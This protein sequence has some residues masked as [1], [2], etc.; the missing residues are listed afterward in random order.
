MKRRSSERDDTLDAFFEGLRDREDAPRPQK[1]LEEINALVHLQLKLNNEHDARVG[2]RPGMVKE[3]IQDMVAAQLTVLNATRLIGAIQNRV[4]E[5]LP[6]KFAAFG[7]GRS[8]RY[9]H[10]DCARRSARAS[11]NA[12]NAQIE[13]DIDAFLQRESADTDAAKLRLL[14]TLSQGTRA[15]FD[16]KT[17]KQVKQVFMPL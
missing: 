13:R 8:R 16:Q 9:D 12:L 5:Q 6:W 7:L 15:T 10:A 11:V 17:H 4:G 2:R 3:D 14:L 1:I